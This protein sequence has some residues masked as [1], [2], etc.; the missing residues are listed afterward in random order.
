M[1]N[2]KPRNLQNIRSKDEQLGDCLK[3]IT[4]SI[5]Y[6]AQQTN[7]SPVGVTPAPTMHAALNV[8]GGNG[9]FSASIVDNSPKFRGHENFLAVSTTKDGFS[10]SSHKIHLGAAKTWYGYLG[11]QN[12]HFASYSAYPTSAPGQAIYA[13]DVNGAAMGAPAIPAN[14][15]GLAGFGA[16]PYTTPTIPVR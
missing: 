1:A 11:P 7:A 14:D 3:D 13:F 6:H 8:T 15:E 5:N 12:L 16:Q 4:D 9:Y 10:S 2:L